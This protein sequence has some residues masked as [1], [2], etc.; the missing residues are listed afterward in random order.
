MTDL[1]WATGCALAGGRFFVRFGACPRKPSS[2][3]VINKRIWVDA[4][5]F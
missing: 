3:L 2:R 4:D 1:G 5:W